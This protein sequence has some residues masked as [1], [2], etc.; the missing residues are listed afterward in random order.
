MIQGIGCDIAKV[1]RFKKGEAFLISFINKN[2][3]T[4]EIDELEKKKKTQN[5]DFLSLAVATRFSAKE[6]VS[7]ALG[8][9]FSQ[10]ISLKDIEVVHDE[11]GAPKVNLYNK[12]KERANK[13]I[14]NNNYQIHITISNEKEYVSTFA[15]IEKI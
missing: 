13:I 7:K 12:A 5:E 14:P 6:A 9:G 11:L 8:S 4:K 15:I 10:G 2:F 1:D 3:T